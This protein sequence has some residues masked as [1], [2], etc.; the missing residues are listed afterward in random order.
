M[1]TGGRVLVIAGLVASLG[2]GACSSAPSRPA[3]PAV[4]SRTTQQNAPQPS[5]TREEALAA[6]LTAR[7]QAIR[8]HDRAAFL[9]TLDN[10]GSGF[11][12]RQLTV[13][14]D[15]AQL[16]LATFS[17]GTPE[18][19]PPLG[20]DRVAQVG[21]DAWVSRIAGRYTIAGFDTAPREF[22]SYFTV[23]RRSDGWKLA[24]DTDGGT[25]PQLWD[26]PDFTVV[27]SPTTLVIG[28]GP[29][30]RL[31]PYLALGDRAVPRVTRVWTVP[32]KQRLVLVVPATAA[33]MA[34]QLG[35]DPGAVDQVAAVTDGPF[36]STG[37][38]GADRVVINPKAFA[39]LQA[40][41][42]QVVVTHEA[43][44]V[45]IR[46]TTDRPVPLWLSEGM[47]DFVGYRDVGVS[48]QLIAA[49]LLDRVRAGKGPTALPSAADF[50]PS[51]STIAPSYNAA[52]LAINRI[53]E[54]FGIPALVR[55]YR[56][57][58]TSP[59]PNAAPG[60][61]DANTQA[62]FRSVL[63]TSQA[64]FTTDWLGYLR[65]LAA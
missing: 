32:W 35:Q 53:V 41:G 8:T 52:W 19:A 58:A 49:A 62:A 31:R 1:N 57:A 2:L 6:V 20:A 21:P 63:H 38:A 5:D 40:R 37:R 3:G 7:A 14:D 43:T 23:V 22:E 29:A 48:K 27:K 11:G 42:Q 51:R 60:D 46:S 61:A 44:H 55:F 17:Y 24:D 4:T 34:E 39:N 28:S 30:S 47:A 18:P 26:L 16:P 36:D 13:F 25:Q 64:A 65:S 59:D 9:A 15:L 56:T 33:Q 10:P 50:D 45:A 54:R 12:L